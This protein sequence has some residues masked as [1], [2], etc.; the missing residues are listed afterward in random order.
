MKMVSGAGEYGW[1]VDYETRRWRWELFQQGHG[2]GFVFDDGHH[3]LAVALWR[4]CRTPSSSR[5]RAS[6]PLQ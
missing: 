5:G 1:Q 3:K 6:G 4:G 2:G